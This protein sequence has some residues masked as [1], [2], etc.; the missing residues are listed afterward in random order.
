MNQASAT[1]RAAQDSMFYGLVLNDINFKDR[2]HAL[3]VT[4]RFGNSLVMKA[5]P[6]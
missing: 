5:L 2:H 3:R 4:M 1:G 6:Y